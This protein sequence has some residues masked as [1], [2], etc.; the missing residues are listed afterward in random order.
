MH[1]VTDHVTLLCSA[2]SSAD[3]LSSS[4]DRPAT[5]AAREDQ[6]DKEDEEEDVDGEEVLRR[7]LIAGDQRSSLSAA[8]GQRRQTNDDETMD[9]REYVT[10]TAGADDAELTRVV[11]NLRQKV[12]RLL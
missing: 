12:G 10:S 3:W 11:S 9:Q 2:E 7:V 8:T 1:F 5:A 6:T 4:R